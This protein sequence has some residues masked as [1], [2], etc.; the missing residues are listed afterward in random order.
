MSR[1]AKR[2]A[3]ALFDL[4]KGD[5]A[6]AKQEQQSLTT[7]SGLFDNADSARVLRSPIMPAD[8]KMALLTYGLDQAEA[9]DEVR[10]LVGT[11]LDV[12]RVNLIPDVVTTYGEMIDEAQGVVKAKLTAAVKPTAE[13]VSSIES[14]LSTMLHKKVQIEAHEDHSLLGGFVVEVGHNLIDLSLKTRLDALAQT[15]VHDTV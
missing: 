5:L 8:L 10:K 11:L 13:D 6:R 2:Y 3:K 12:G 14:S 15:A 9:N 7:L 1:I 4:A